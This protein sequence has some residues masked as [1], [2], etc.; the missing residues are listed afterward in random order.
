MF[1]PSRRPMSACAAALATA[2]VS[3]HALAQVRPG[4]DTRFDGPE[5]LED[6]DFAIDVDSNGN[7][8]CAGW[9]YSQANNYDFL[10]AKFDRFG[11][12]LWSRTYDGPA[13][14]S[15][16]CFTLTLD[17]QGNV[18][19]Y[20]H[21]YGGPTAGADLVTLKYDPSGNLLW[22]RRYDRPSGGDDYV[23]GSDMIG[24]DAAGNVYIAAYSTPPS[25]I[26]ETVVVKYGPN[27][28]FQWARHEPGPNPAFPY[29][30]GYSLEVTPAGECYAAAD[31]YGN[32]GTY[33]IGVVKYDTDGTRLWYAEID[34]A[35][36]SHETV[37]A[38]AVD[39]D[40][41]FYVS[42]L[43]DTSGGFDAFLAQCDGAT[44]AKTWEATYGNG[45]GFHYPWCL[46]IDSQ[47]NVCLSMA[48][49]TPGGGEYDTITNK[50][51]P[52]G[53]LLWS[54][55]HRTEWFGDDWPGTLALD[56]ADN[57]YVTGYSWNGYGPDDD[58]FTV[59]Y[60]PDGTLEWTELYNGAASGQDSG[61]DVEVDAL[62]SVHVGGFSLGFGTSTDF[63][64]LKYRQ[65]S[66][67]SLAVSPDPLV[68]GSFATFTASGFEPDSPTY[69]AY[70]LVGP[71]ST[72]VPPLN[73]TLDLAN[74]S[75]AGG[76][77]ISDASGTAMWTIFIPNAAAGLDVWIQAAQY[78]QTTQVVATSVE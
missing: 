66:L 14:G 52:S 40:G 18:Y 64:I 26:E 58:A 9:T 33:D 35:S 51:S 37:Y 42:G 72:P 74:P 31:I 2:F 5:S 15:D 22:E 70:S 68:A 24:L 10:L 19:V 73:V 16:E 34:A 7:T 38:M 77:A 62:G 28:A 54:Q 30:L 41:N 76:P 53:A 56:A 27:G 4:W 32:G 50:Y 48:A 61:F 63:L 60:A 17:P 21:S 11:A 55:R 36:H 6:V 8:Y 43:S 59:K 75:Q 45:L 78:G 69:L 29:A 13:H 20:G 67:P 12:P 65:G 1:V 44:G 49:T 23:F 3:T 47:R 46:A 39:P 25:L 71:G 57:L